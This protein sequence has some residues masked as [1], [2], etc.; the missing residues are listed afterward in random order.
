M[1]KATVLLLLFATLSFPV[2]RLFYLMGTYAV[3]DLPAEE[4]VYRTY[5]Y[6]REIERKLSSYREDSEISLINRKAGVEP[7]PVSPETL[8]VLKKAVH[9]YRL[10]W[11]SFDITRNDAGRAGAVQDL[12]IEGNRVFLKRRGVSLDLGGIGKG[13][14][15]EMAYRNTSAEWGFL[16]IAG[17][18]KVWGHRRVLGVKDPL[19]GGIF[20][21]MVNA[22]DLC[23][24][25]SGNYHRRHI[26]VKDPQLV[27]LTVVFE[28][29]TFADALA[30]ALFSMDREQRRR[31]L[32]ENPG[33]GVLEVYRDGSF[34]VNGSFLTYFTSILFPEGD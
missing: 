13:Y 16:G 29:C 1:R 4:E 11:G 23:L 30:T 3:I 18:M 15:V 10:T 28:D 33:V 26:K 14:A 6:M 9:I 21:L 17:D 22:R 12:K 27:Q 24:S 2:Q 7:V 8:E 31:F 32:S 5:R 25:T 20:L 19:R 34:Y